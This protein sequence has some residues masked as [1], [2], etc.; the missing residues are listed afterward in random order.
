MGRWKGFG[1]GGEIC[2]EKSTATRK[3]NFFEKSSDA[4]LPLSLSLSV[5]PTRRHPP[6]PKAPESTPSPHQATRN[7][8]TSRSRGEEREKVERLVSKEGR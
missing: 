2:D 1:G 3:K 5:S 8:V 6:P 7:R 4:A